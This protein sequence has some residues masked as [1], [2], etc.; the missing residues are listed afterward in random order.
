MSSTTIH[1]LLYETDKPCMIKED[2]YAP[3]LKYALER[4]KPNFQQNI[5]S[6]LDNEEYETALNVY[7][8]TKTYIQSLLK[9]CIGHI[10]STTCSWIECREAISF[11]THAHSVMHY[12][13]S[14]EE[15]ASGEHVRCIF[16]GRTDDITLAQFTIRHNNNNNQM[17]EEVSPVF[18]YHQDFKI[19]MSALLLIG[20]FDDYLHYIT[21]D[22]SKDCTN[23]E[24]L[25]TASKFFQAV[26]DA[27]KFVYDFF[28]L[29]Y[30]KPTDPT[31]I[32][33]LLCKR[34]NINCVSI[35][36]NVMST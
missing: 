25:A 11:A 30:S 20:R 27:S 1:H 16:T 22:L 8:I 14:K 7:H 33:P 6:N 10:P 12:S 9:F 17:K 28:Y 3:L 15:E 23:P 18:A 24:K 36:K 32:R 21:M 5:E 19:V 13:I 2:N 29:L 35:C 26:N 31:P 34:N 4:S